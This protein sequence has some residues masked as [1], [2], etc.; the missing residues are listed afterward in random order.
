[1]LE[2]LSDEIV[3]KC[4]NA[5]HSIAD[6]YERLD[7]NILATQDELW[8]RAYVYLNNQIKH[9]RNL[10]LIHYSVYGSMYPRGYP[11]RYGLPEARWKDFKDNG[12]KSSRGKREHYELVLCKKEIKYTLGYI[13]ECIEN[14][15]LLKN[16]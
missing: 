5:V 14:I 2:K 10:E 11:M 12:R 4:V 15:E 8:F 16:A 7:K 6:Y 9:D 1:M 3:L 13:L